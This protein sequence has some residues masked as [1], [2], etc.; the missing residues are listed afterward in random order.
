MSSKSQQEKD[1][2]IELEPGDY[3]VQEKQPCDA[4][5]IIQEGQLAAFRLGKQGKIP[6]GLI[7]SGEYV[8][9]AAIFLEGHH[10]STVMALTKVK[11]LK[12]PKSSIEAQLKNMPSWMVALARG[13]VTRLHHS[14]EILR[15]NAWIDPTIQQKVKAI[16]EKNPS[17]R[18]AS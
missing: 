1:L 18:K 9:E 11:A 14:N 6:V 12:I 17:R 4:L 5:Y 16:S 10:L 8:G 7:S 15:R 13:L 2:T 3:L